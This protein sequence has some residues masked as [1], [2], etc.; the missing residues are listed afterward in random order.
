MRSSRVFNYKF[1]GMVN[2]GFGES[3]VNYC[4]TINILGIL[5]KGLKKRER[6]IR[7]TLEKIAED[8]CKEN[9]QEEVAS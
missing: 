3:H 7:S 2:G 4:C 1:S 6:E 5:K 8:A 9:F